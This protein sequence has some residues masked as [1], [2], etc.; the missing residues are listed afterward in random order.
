M[1][2]LALFACSD[3]Q[4]GGKSDRNRPAEETG[5]HV[6]DTSVD[7]TDDSADTDEVPV[8]DS[9]GDTSVEFPEGKIDVVLIMDIAYSYDCYRVELASRTSELINALFDSGADVAVSISTYD[10]YNVEGEW[11]VAWGGVP[12]VLE[13]QLTTDRATALT[14]AGGL[15]FNWGGDGPGTGYEAILQSM[16]GRGYDQDCDGTFD[17]DNDIRAFNASGSDAFGGGA[18]G[19]ANSSVPGTGTLPGVGFRGGSKKVVVVFAENSIRDRNEG[20]EIPTGVCLG[21]ASQSDAVSGMNSMDVKFLGINAYEF[22]DIDTRPQEQLEALATQ[23][24]SK[25][26]KDGDGARDDVAVYGGD[27]NWPTTAQIVSGVWDLAQ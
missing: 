22:W 17:S 25:I 26:D 7:D 6:V 16:N 8:T 27:W 10:D 18:T 3:Y 9:D 5:E 24:S 23:T 15:D 21:A 19:Y 11:W 2:L 1:L 4:L 13:Q 14:A 20:D 12:Y